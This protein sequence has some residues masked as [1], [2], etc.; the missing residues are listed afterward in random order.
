MSRV[1]HA[2]VAGLAAPSPTL[3]AIGVATVLYS[4]TLLWSCL[5]LR[6]GCRWGTCVRAM[7]PAYGGDVVD[8]DVVERLPLSAGLEEVGRA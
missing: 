7:Q 3:L 1:L 6:V 4:T 2:P 5:L 8:E